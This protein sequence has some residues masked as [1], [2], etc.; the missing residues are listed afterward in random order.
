METFKYSKNLK[1]LFFKVRLLMN[2]SLNE[3]D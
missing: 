3:L 1:N 2:V